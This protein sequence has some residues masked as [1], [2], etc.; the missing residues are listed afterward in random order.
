MRVKWFAAVRVVSRCVLKI[1]ENLWATHCAILLRGRGG[2]THDPTTNTQ[3]SCGGEP[4][5]LI[6]HGFCVRALR[7]DQP[8]LTGGGKCAAR[9]ALPIRSVAIRP[10]QV[11]RA[12]RLAS[13]HRSLPLATQRRLH[14]SVSYGTIAQLRRMP[15]FDA[16]GAFAQYAA[17]C[18]GRLTGW[19]KRTCTDVIIVQFMLFCI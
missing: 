17:D 10:H 2:Y 11:D 6:L 16:Y 15:Q 12:P 4:N 3:Q 1:A 19:P 5:L 13:C 8:R 7:P 9:N 14:Q 18:A